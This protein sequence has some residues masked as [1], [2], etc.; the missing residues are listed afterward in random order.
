MQ[1]RGHQSAPVASGHWRSLDLRILVIEDG[2]PAAN[3]RVGAPSA[4]LPSGG[5]TAQLTCPRPVTVAPQ[6]IAT[7][8]ITSGAHA[9]SV[10]FRVTSMAWEEL[11]AGAFWR[12]SYSML[13]R[14]VAAIVT[15]GYQTSGNSST[16]A[17]RALVCWHGG[18]DTALGWQGLCG[19]HWGD[20]RLTYEGVWFWF[21]LCKKC[22]SK[23]TG[24]QHQTMR[25][26]KP[27]MAR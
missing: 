4:R 7:T 16:P 20:G 13:C 9:G 14:M 18:R 6:S 22:H 1:I 15:R 26:S 11:S 5:C 21:L 19:R 25:I 23:L 12:L 8:G 10:P 2:L 3:A 27:Q 17:F 24:L